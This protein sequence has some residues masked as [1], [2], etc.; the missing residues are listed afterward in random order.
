MATSS[1]ISSTLEAGSVQELVR[2]LRKH[3]PAIIA[4]TAL[5][6][7]I[8][9]LYARSS[10]KVYEATSLVEIDPQATQPLGEKGSDMLNMG[11][12]M[13][14]DTRDYYETQYKLISSDRVLG[15]AVRELGLIADPEFAP[16]R[17]GDGHA[18]EDAIGA[19]RGRLIVDPQKGSR[20]VLI[21]V[22]DT[23]PERAKRLCDA[24]ASAYV[25]Q[26]LDTAIGG[27]GD[28]VVW[29]NGQLD[30][31]KL[32]LEK[33]EN[34]LFDFKRDN[35]LPST[36]INDAA[37]MLRV[38]M[39]ELDTALTHTR[40][41]KQ[42]LLARYSELSKVNP[43][44]PDQLSASE[45]L[46][47][48]FLLELRRQYEG[49]QQDL[50]TVLG[51]G[52]GENHPAAKSAAEKVRI[53]RDA[54]MS[55]IRNIQGAV[56][57][58]LAVVN[59]EETGEARLFEETRK[60]AVD[61]NMK[62]I[63]FHRLDRAKD[64][65]EKLYELLLER[66]KESD[67]ARMTKANNIRVVDEAVQPE[68][69]IRP[70]SMLITIVGTIIGLLAGSALTWLR[71]Q[72]DSSTKTPEDVEQKLNTTFLGLLPEYDDEGDAGEKRKGSRRR[73]RHAEREVLKSRDL[74][75]HARPLSGVA[76]AAR[77]IRTNLL[78]MNPDRPFR[79]MLVTSA[80][81]SEGKTTVVCSLAIA[82]AQG[83][84]RVCV[85]DCDL[86]RPR[87]HRIFG[88]EGDPGITSVLLGEATLDDVTKPTQIR[89]L[90][91]VP[92]GHI[93]PNPADILHSARFKRL[94][95]E[96]AERFDR[97]V[98]DSPPVVAVTDAT[99]LS[100][101]V[102]GVLFVIRA[103]AT[104]RE[105]SAHGL[106]AL[107]DVDAPIA[108]AVLNAVNP[109]RRDGSYYYRYYYY[110]NNYGPRTEQPAVQPDEGEDAAS[111]N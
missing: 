99:I 57:R 96:L 23:K 78:F 73:R 70:R 98:I 91:S 50:A 95:G 46:S 30:H 77:S 54:L 108:G 67:V 13:F 104:P 87:L 75:V 68:H 24:V 22:D 93:P 92:A 88:R 4:L 45:L 55:E 6:A 82:L 56:E 44:T 106:R 105:V 53:A 52:K 110:R 111:P 5:G 86:R 16:R 12:G 60:R 59:R 74:V 10:S 26:N 107:R 32:D 21:R 9:L 38:E 94:V 19:L 29:L 83:G 97:V 7:G 63:E 51:N 17:N 41:K 109:R 36:S 66:S 65:N 39:Q 58:D 72:L 100:T 33:S 69:P 2:A 3:W 37:N 47:S 20:L 49:A 34:A 61:L 15:M 27:T 71:E 43:D 103:F 40:T 84:Q 28:A 90:W 42:E 101:L 14:W 35:D 81:P 76:E 8:G 18:L 80:A 25:Q 31:I 64:Q 11:A 48:P 79:T 62:E 102:D 1:D 85:I 89:N